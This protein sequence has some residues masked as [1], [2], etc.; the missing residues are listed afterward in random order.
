[1][2]INRLLSSHGDSED[3]LFIH[4]TS[5]TYTY[6]LVILDM[7]NESSNKQVIKVGHVHGLW[8][9]SVGVVVGEERDDV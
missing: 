9:S 8:P 1:M 7:N 5:Q 2:Y 4:V 6:I 3:C